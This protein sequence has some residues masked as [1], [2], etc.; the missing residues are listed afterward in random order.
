MVSFSFRYDISSEANCDNSTLSSEQLQN[1]HTNLVSIFSSGNLEKMFQT[2]VDCGDGLE[3]YLNTM[4]MTNQ[5][6][7]VQEISARYTANI[8]VLVACGIDSNSTNDRTHNFQKLR[9]FEYESNCKQ[10]LELSTLLSSKTAASDIE[11]LFRDTLEYRERN[12]I[13]CNDFIQ[14]LIDMQKK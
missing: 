13:K 3:Q 10:S 12:D 14:L 7:D 5:L 1:H 2:I 11:S 4:Y 9:R 6:M 8:I